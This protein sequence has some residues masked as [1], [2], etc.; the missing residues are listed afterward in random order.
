MTKLPFPTS[1]RHVHCP[2]S[3]GRCE[4]WVLPYVASLFLSFPPV[5]LNECSLPS[6][7]SFRASHCPRSYDSFANPIISLY[8]ARTSCSDWTFMFPVVPFGFSTARTHLLCETARS[9]DHSQAG[10]ETIQKQDDQPRRS[11]VPLVSAAVSIPR[12]SLSTNIRILLFCSPSMESKVT[13]A[14]LQESFLSFI[15]TCVPWISQWCSFEPSY[16]RTMDRVPRCHIFCDRT[17]ERPVPFLSCSL[18]YHFAKF[19]FSQAHQ[20]RNTNFPGL[21]FF[22]G[23]LYLGRAVERR[24]WYLVPIALA[25][26]RKKTRRQRLWIPFIAL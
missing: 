24:N 5:L 8:D 15:C 13:C 9:Y 3:F 6:P 21:L 1:P 20:K 10:W 12:R 2:P 23:I 18:I 16:L 14:P 26:P 22:P 4:S 7:L 17:C 25:G 11:G 19:P